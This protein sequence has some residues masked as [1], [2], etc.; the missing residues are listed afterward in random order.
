M[1]RNKPKKWYLVSLSC[2]GH[3]LR[4]AGTMAAATRKVVLRLVAPDIEYQVYQGVAH[5][6]NLMSKSG[7]Q[8][9]Q[10]RKINQ[11]GHVQ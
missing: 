10:Q 11:N 7:R 1:S 4:T 8:Q 5:P 3:A 6:D 9:R 2:I